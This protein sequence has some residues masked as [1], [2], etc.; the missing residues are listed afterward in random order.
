MAVGKHTWFGRFGSWLSDNFSSTRRRD[1]GLGRFLDGVDNLWNSVTGS[2]LTGAQREAN[3]YSASQ[4]EAAF[5]READFYEKQQ[6]YKA[7]LNQAIEAG[8]NPFSVAGSPGASSGLASASPSSVT[9][10]QDANKLLEFI[11]GLYGLKL[12]K[13][14]V[15]ADANLKNAQA[16]A[17]EE[18][19]PLEL[20]EI[21]SRVKHNDALTQ[22]ELQFT[23]N[24]LTDKKLL[25]EQIG[26]TAA[27]ADKVEEEMQYYV[28]MANTINGIRDAKVRQARAEALISEWQEENKELFKGIE[29]GTDVA[30]MLIDVGTAVLNARTGLKIAGTERRS[31]STNTNTNTNTSS[32]HSTN[33]NYN[34]RVSQ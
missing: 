17:V 26:L 22:K 28:A 5:A 12:Q 32:S 6:S 11:T 13:Q 1:D 16:S 4:A 10:Q 25:E 3:A 27:Q 2:G 31:V 18:K 34:Y 14:Q 33:H 29:I 30:G 19:L 21:A 7:Q 8:A 23:E 15:E 20:S 24:L 9:P